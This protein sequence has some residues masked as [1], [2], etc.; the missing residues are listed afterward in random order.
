MSGQVN[1]EKKEN[2]GHSSMKHILMMVFCCGLP[3]LLSAVIPFLKIENTAFRVTLISIIPF[4]CPLIM[5][6]M[7]L[8]GSKEGKSSCHDNKKKQL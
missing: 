1:D 4:L 7:M 8:K 6:P 5:L 2:K 3:I